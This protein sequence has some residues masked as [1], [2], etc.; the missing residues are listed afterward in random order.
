MINT[1]HV[2][3]FKSI[4][5]EEISL[6][7]INVIIG[8]NGSGKSNFLE[9]L[10]M[11]S[12]AISQKTDNEYLAN[13]GVRV[14]APQLMQSGFD[15]YSS[16]EIKLQAEL[17]FEK[18]SYVLSHDGKAYS[19]WK[20]EE[21]SEDNRALKELFKMANYVA[22]ETQKIDAA[23]T[24]VESIS[25]SDK[26]KKMLLELDLRKRI[27]EI[28]KAQE[29]LQSFTNSQDEA[30][31]KIKSLIPESKSLN[32]FKDFTIYSPENSAL[33]DFN[34]HDSSLPLGVNGQGLFKLLN[35][36]K[37]E[38]P[39]KFHEIIDYMNVFIWF[40]SFDLTEQS[41]E[42]GNKFHIKDKFIHDKI[43]DQRSINE[44]FLFVLF[45]IT[46]IISDQTPNAFAID[47]I[48]T[49]LNPKLCIKLIKDI[50]SLSKKHNKQ[51]FLSTHNPAILDGLD[52]N[53]SEQKL[54]VCSRSKDGHTKFKS[55]TPSERLITKDGAPI[56]L[57]DAL[58]RG[59]IGG[60]PKRF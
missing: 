14:T 30:L 58:M 26:A 21:S 44:G 17:N 47:N 15:D 57:S 41:N 3:K 8:E 43:L 12:A 39:N 19:S 50:T 10:A 4:L 16:L 59:Y 29:I 13:R 24:E 27:K 11:L 51:I 54:I 23:L 20:V 2:N 1:I 31:R 6:G 40:D 45:Y 56:K 18:H 53:D 46:L 55:F 42:E 37:N 25:D 35:V 38:N 34:S 52:L 5:N 48:D 7:R 36:M 32:Y 28:A 9:S 22:S 60:L 33:R 49:S